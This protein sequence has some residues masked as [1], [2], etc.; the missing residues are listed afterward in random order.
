VA[1]VKI[2]DKNHPQLR[3]TA[4][5][6]T[7]LDKLSVEMRCAFGASCAERL[8]PMYKAFSIEAKWGE[9]ERLRQAIDDLWSVATLATVTVDYSEDTLLDL[10]P[11]S[12]EHPSRFTFAAQHAVSCVIHAWN[13]RRARTSDEAAWCSI[14]NRDCIS[15]YLEWLTCPYYVNPNEQ[16]RSELSAIDWFPHA[17]MQHEVRKQLKD[18][19]LLGNVPRLDEATVFTLRVAG[20]R[21]VA[22]FDRHLV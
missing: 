5:V 18:L 8:Y 3:T 10:A 16:I 2:D 17:L 7:M 15:E 4:T 20:A 13:S 1:L 6:L 9:P 14:V 12:A 22:P 21:G 11:R 19:E